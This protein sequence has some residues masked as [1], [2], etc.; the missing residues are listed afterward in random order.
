MPPLQG[1]IQRHAGA[2][3]TL[4][5]TVNVAAFMLAHAVGSM[6]GAGVVTAAGL[7]WTGLAGA[8][9]SAAGLLLSY[10]AVPRLTAAARL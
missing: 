10:R 1:L 7:R 8:A 3:P 4:A 5:V 9:L 2:A 6:I